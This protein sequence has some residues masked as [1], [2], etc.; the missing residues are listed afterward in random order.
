M[1]DETAVHRRPFLRLG[2]PHCLAVGIHPEGSLRRACH[3]LSAPDAALAVHADLDQAAGEDP[4]TG[5]ADRITGQVEGRAGRT[6]PLVHQL[7]GVL[8]RK[9][10]HVLDPRLHQQ[11]RWGGPA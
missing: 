1:A 11:E 6:I 10:R 8:E 2:R 5:A 7:S 9:H 4:Q 3:A